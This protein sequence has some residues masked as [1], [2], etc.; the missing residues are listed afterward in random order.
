MKFNN[1]LYTIEIFKYIYQCL[2]FF[3]ASK[4]KFE[5]KI[6]NFLQI[7]KNNRRQNIL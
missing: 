4:K 2:L 5:D 3:F 7:D 6:N 1:S